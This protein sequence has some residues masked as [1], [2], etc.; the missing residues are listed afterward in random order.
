MKSCRWS[1]VKEASWPYTNSLQF[2]PTE[3]YSWENASNVY[4][5]LCGWVLHTLQTPVKSTKCH[6]PT[7]VFGSRCGLSASTVFIFYK[8]FS[9][10]ACVR[11]SKKGECKIC[12]RGKKMSFWGK[13]LVNKP[14]SQPL[15]KKSIPLIL[16]IRPL[17]FTLQLVYPSSSTE[18]L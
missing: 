2:L 6:P 10:I 14:F 16:Y 8:G 12:R 13:L 9:T 5:V 3:L 18:E 4:S 15:V 17:L 1:K 7:S 11:K